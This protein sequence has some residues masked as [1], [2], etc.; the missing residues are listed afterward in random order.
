MVVEA[1]V[2]DRARVASGSSKGTSRCVGESGASH[3]DGNAA[4]PAVHRARQAAAA[5]G[6]RA[7]NAALNRNAARSDVARCNAPDGTVVATL[8]PRRL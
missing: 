8:L 1:A 5:R 6:R 4:H 7:N 2:V 3:C